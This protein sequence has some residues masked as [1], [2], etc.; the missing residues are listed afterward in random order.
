MWRRQWNMWAVRLVPG[1]AAKPIVD[2]SVVVPTEAD[3][4]VAIARLATL[5]YAHLGT[6]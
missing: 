4:P 2:I 6:R 1:L 3:V 5:G